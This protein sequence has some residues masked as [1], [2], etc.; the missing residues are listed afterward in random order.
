MT[1]IEAKATATALAVI[2]VVKLS[3]ELPD[4][5]HHQ[6]LPV[7]STPAEHGQLLAEL[8]IKLWNARFRAGLL[9]ADL[10]T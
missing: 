6:R 9:K 1:K 3:N 4:A 10:C 2:D 7:T 5:G 8:Q